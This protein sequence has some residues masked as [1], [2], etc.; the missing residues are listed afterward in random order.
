MFTVT[1]EIC[2]GVSALEIYRKY[3]L[4]RPNVTHKTFF[5]KYQNGKCNK[6]VVGIH[7]FGK[8]PSVIAK[9]LQ[10]PNS[11]EYTGH[12]FRRTSA[13]LLADAGGDILTLKR[14]GGWKSSTVAEGYVEDS[15]TNKVEIANKILKEKNFNINATTP[16]FTSAVANTSI[17]NKN[18][19][20]TA[21]GVN[22]NNCNKCT[23]TI[24]YTINK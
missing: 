9:Y 19:Q 4:L 20:D 1:D 10:L 18:V 16:N 23:I 8:M 24:N 12:C 13:S 2:D 3:T 22:L 17:C 6:Q 5:L 21:S 11:N 7:T 15:I 14:H